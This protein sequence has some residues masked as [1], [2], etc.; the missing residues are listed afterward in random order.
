MATWRA[1]EK[2]AVAGG[3]CSSR[4]SFVVGTTKTFV[5]ILAFDDAAQVA[6]QITATSHK[7]DQPHENNFL[8]AVSYELFLIKIFRCISAISAAISGALVLPE[9]PFGPN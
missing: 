8:F 6:Q 3:V 5:G 7:R 2:A 9:R 4:R 1:W